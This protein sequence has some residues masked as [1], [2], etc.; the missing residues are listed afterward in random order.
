MRIQY[1]NENYSII[2]TNLLISGELFDY[3]KKFDYEMND[4]YDRLVE[5]YKIKWN[6]TG[7]LKV[8]D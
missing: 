4:F 2:Y 1:L 3:L 8:K 6:I 5:Q 7:K